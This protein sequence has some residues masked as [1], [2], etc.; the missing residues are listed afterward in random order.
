[1][2]PQDAESVEDALFFARKAARVAPE[3]RPRYYGDGHA[4]AKMVQALRERGL[5][6]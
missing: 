2:N 1:M 5:T 4:A 3:E 6:G